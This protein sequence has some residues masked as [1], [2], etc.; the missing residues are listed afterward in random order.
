MNR[1]PVCARRIQVD[2]GPQ[3]VKLNYQ[4]PPPPG[5]R[6]GRYIDQ[7]DL[8]DAVDENAESDTVMNNGRELK[9]RATLETMGFQLEYWPTGVED[10]E[11][12]DQITSRYYAEMRELVKL[13]TGANKVFV[14]DHTVRSSEA[15][16]LNALEVG[17]TAAAVPRVHADYTAESA[18]RRLEQYGKAGIYSLLKDRDLTQE[19]VA[20]L[21]SGRFMFINVWRGIT[22]EPVQR[23]PLACCDTNSVSDSDRFLYELIFPD[24]IGE[25]YSM[26]FSPNHQWYYYPNQTKDECLVFKTY[27]KKEDGPRFCFHTAFNDP[28]TTPD[29]PT[30]R[31]IEIRAIAFFPNE[32]DMTNDDMN[33]APAPVDHLA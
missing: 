3:T 17:A 28:R 10:F 18:P 31:S 26:Q 21:S 8:G 22:D 32:T 19:E 6:T 13:S 33:A 30:R 24:R 15:K 2:A 11:D 29:S 9:P 12:Q 20:A 5:K 7:P 27:D 16:S 25:N 4:V 1:L 23:M 14:F